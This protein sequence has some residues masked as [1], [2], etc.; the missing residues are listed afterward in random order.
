MRPKIGVFGLT[1]CAG[2]QL[3]LI[4]CEDEVLDLAS[5]FQISSF[6][7]AQSVND[8]SELDV[9]FVEGAVVTPGDESRLKDIRSKAR[10]LVAL[11]TCAT[12]GG[13]AGG[14]GG[15]TIREMYQEVYRTG[16][17]I[18]EYSPP[19]PLRDFVEVDAAVPGCPVEKHDLLRGLSGLLYGLL[20]LAH[21]YSVCFECKPKENPC[22][23]FTGLKSCS[24]PVTAGGCGARCPSHNV[25]CRGCRG[26]LE[27][28]SLESR[29]RMLT[30]AGGDGS[31]P[32]LGPEEACRALCTF[33]RVESS[34]VPQGKEGRD[35]D[36]DL[37]G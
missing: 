2:D 18:Y 1:S 8:D 5:E 33:S 34:Q 25:R 13:V 30:A 22:Q 19:A 14:V 16:R 11:G 29:L 26:P 6:S 28:D 20:P 10:L 7:M 31:G 37:G 24:G 9:A 36:Q 15:Q 3:A 21:D 17:N 35:L 4:N 12:W 32:I 27:A 23:L